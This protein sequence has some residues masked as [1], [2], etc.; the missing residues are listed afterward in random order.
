MAAICSDIA[1]LILTSPRVYETLM[2]EFTAGKQ[3]MM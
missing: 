2:P 3:Y 1:V